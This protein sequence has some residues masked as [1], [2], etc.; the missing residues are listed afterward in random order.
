MLTLNGLSVAFGP[1]LLFDDVNLNLNAGSRYGVVGANGTGKSTLLKVI[2]GEEE[3][4]LGEVSFPKHARIGWLKQ[5]HFE[6]E[7][8]KILYA[9]MRGNPILWKAMEEK[10][11]LLEQA[12]HD[13][14]DEMGY[15]LGEL[16]EIIAQQDGYTAEA[17]AENLLIGLGIPKSQHHK[18]LATF[19]GGYKLRALLAQA[20]F[21]DPEILLLDEPTNHLDIMSIAW[22]EDYLKNQFK[23][24]LVFISHD[25]SFLNNLS[26]HI[27]D[28]DYGDIRLYHGNYESFLKQREELELQKASERRS[29][30]KK[31]AQLQSFVDRFKAKAT[32]ARQAQSKLKMIDRI[33]M[34][35]VEHSSRRF[36]GFKFNLNRSSGRTV[37]TVKG[38]NK[39]YGEKKVLSNVN[40]S[41]AKGER[42]VFIG[43]NGIG[44]STLL[45]CVQDLVPADSG[46]IEWGHETHPSYFA[47][48]HHEQLFG[49]SSAMAWL[50]NA[51]VNRTTQEV[52]S[53]LG[54]VLFSQD[55][56]LKTVA[57]LS[58]GEGARLLLGRMML[59]RGNVLIL[60]EPTNHLDLESIQA[61]IK[62]LQSFEGTIFFV[63]HDRSFVNQIATRVIALTEK[64]IK[65]YKG[66]YEEYLHHVGADYLSKTWLAGQGG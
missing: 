39:S 26:T 63:S 53:I 11:R 45:K 47:Q 51:V 24:L 13:W 56:A 42:V 43:H 58:G 4:T 28:I 10:D 22:L 61:L 23:G 9:A 1:R 3:A 25:L 50:E 7:Q 29:A 48:D 31:I 36:P 57:T 14:T 52:R 38:L 33:E 59:E 35:D 41:I 62:A 8:D 16:E 65:D 19:S 32:K 44:K 6:Y 64:G 27:L 30:E 34:P 60:D 55:D 54:Q 66:T 40:F 37:L 15:R 49:P 5:D 18:P 12:A 46:V 17:K 20:L 2:C 21:N